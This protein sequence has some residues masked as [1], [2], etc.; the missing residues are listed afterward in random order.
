MAHLPSARSGASGRFL[1][2]CLIIAAGRG[3]RL[4][5]K[6]ASKPLAA[7]AGRP[8]IEHVIRRARAGG[9]TRFL[10]VTGYEAA[11]IERFLSGLA[12]A[13][14]I[15][16]ETIRN[17]AWERPNGHSV[18]AAAPRLEREFLLLMADHLFDPEILAALV[19]EE[20]KA[21]L[22]LAVDYAIDNP[23]IDLDDATK[24]QVDANG[25]IA[26]LGK[27]LG[28]YNAIDTGL[29]RSGPALVEAIRR[30][31][32]EGAAG[33]LSEG[34]Q[35]LAHEGDARVLDIAGRWWLDVD[36]PPALALAEE[37]LGAPNALI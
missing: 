16:I 4:R 35:L 29:F 15:P 21:A 9:A 8:L 25:R 22:V 13:E 30:R 1:M 7:V 37:R 10:V 11:G 5:S 26:R 20:S 2:Q 33:S 23:L 36:D 27:T 32:A 17:E 6:A 24:V 18:L 28:G 12:S 34:V 3:G 31:V 14:G 19:A